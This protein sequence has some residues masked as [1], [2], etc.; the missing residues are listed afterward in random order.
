M[1]FLLSIAYGYKFATL[2]NYG[3]CD[4]SHALTEYAIVCAHSFLYAFF[5]LRLCVLLIFLCCAQL[6]VWFIY[7]FIFFFL[8]QKKKRNIVKH[9]FIFCFF[10]TTPRSTVQSRPKATLREFPVCCF[11]LQFSRFYC[12]EIRGKSC[13]HIFV[14]GWRW[15]S[16]VFSTLQIQMLHSQ[17]WWFSPWIREIWQ[18]SFFF[19]I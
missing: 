14:D 8:L 2:F 4:Y 13:V 17:C 18:N 10:F 7:Y 9:E 3:F 19:V 1:L 12:I 11:C 5:S 6:C 15:N 16:L